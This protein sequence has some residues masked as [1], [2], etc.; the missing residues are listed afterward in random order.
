M[1]ATMKPTPPIHWRIARHIRMPR[2]VPS[3]PVI[4][5]DPVVVMPDMASKKAS[6][7]DRSQSQSGKA[8]AAAAIIQ[9]LPVSRKE[10][11]RFNLPRRFIVLRPMNPPTISVRRAASAKI[12][13]VA[14]NSR[15][16]RAMKAP[17]PRRSRLLM[18]MTKGMGV[19]N[20][21]EPVAEVGIRRIEG[22]GGPVLAEPGRSRQER[23]CR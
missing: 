4:T 8:P 20:V 2:S 7:K 17:S 6:V 11:R 18:K 15:A 3:S 22:R 23:P 10:C 1:P 21:P 13:R 9:V 14:G 5:V 19:S 12:V 16:S